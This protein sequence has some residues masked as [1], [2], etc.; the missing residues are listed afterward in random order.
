M[1]SVFPVYFL[2]HHL[3]GQNRL[4]SSAI[5]PGTLLSTASITIHV[6]FPLTVSLWLLSGPS[7]IIRAFYC[8][9]LVRCLLPAMLHP[10]FFARMDQTFRIISDQIAT[11]C[12]DQGF[13][14]Q[15]IVVRIAILYQR[16]LHCLFM[17]IF[18]HI[19]RFHCARIISGI[20]HTRRDC[21]WRRIKI[22]HLLR[23]I[24][25]IS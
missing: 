8:F 22:L 20:I 2:D 6:R 5:A 16:T 19:Y 15:I 4:F 10:L 11:V 9:F 1:S 17:R 14:D 18:R 23:H 3:V 13:L 7:P 12:F 24:T 21:G 25:K